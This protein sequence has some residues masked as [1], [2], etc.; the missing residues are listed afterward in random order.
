MRS[1]P[2]SFLVGS[3]ALGRVCK[4]GLAGGRTG[5]SP[6]RHTM[7]LAEDPSNQLRNWTRAGRAH[8]SG[9]LQTRPSFSPEL[10]RLK[11]EHKVARRGE[12]WELTAEGRLALGFEGGARSVHVLSAVGTLLVGVS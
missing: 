8:Q 6:V 3:S 9:S 4:L 5:F 11:G 1:I 10:S 12:I 7:R 2:A